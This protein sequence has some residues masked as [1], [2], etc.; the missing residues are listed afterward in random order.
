MEKDDVLTLKMLK[1]CVEILKGK[2]NMAGRKMHDRTNIDID[3]FGGMEREMMIREQI[4]H[5]R[6][7]EQREKER[8]ANS[9]PDMVQRNEY[10]SESLENMHKGGLIERKKNPVPTSLSNKD[11][12]LL[13]V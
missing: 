1:D 9:R 7:M 13:L 4:R 8:Y 3:S 5:R 12:L 11:R 6:M 2:S 10:D